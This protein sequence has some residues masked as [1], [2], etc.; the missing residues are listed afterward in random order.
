MGPRRVHKA[1]QALGRLAG[2]GGVRKREGGGLARE[3]GKRRWGK[4]GAS[5]GAGLF[6]L[7]DMLVRL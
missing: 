5:W 1:R 2:V 3:A 4:A 7:E 6:R